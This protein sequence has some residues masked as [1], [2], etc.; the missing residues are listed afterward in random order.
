FFNLFSC[1]LGDEPMPRLNK[2]LI[3]VTLLGW[4]SMICGAIIFANVD[5]ATSGNNAKIAWFSFGTF[6]T[7]TGFMAGIMVPSYQIF[8]QGKNAF[9]Q[10]KVDQVD[11]EKEYASP[12]LEETPRSQCTIL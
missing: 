2:P 12:L 7:I 9:W 10:G 1:Y 3:T 8:I 11:V 4:M 5:E 6:M